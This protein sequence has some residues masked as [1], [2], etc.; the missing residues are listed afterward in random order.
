[1]FCT[2]TKAHIVVID[3]PLLDT[4]KYQDNL[5]NLITDLVLQILSW[6]AEEERTKIKVRQQEGIHLAKK[7]GKH[8]G[9]PRVEITEDFIMA[10]NSWQTGKVTAVEAMKQANL[11]KT[12]F[13]RLVKRF[14]N[15]T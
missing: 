12:T 10:Y 3:M 2:R 7:Q 13:Y 5:G 6:L 1:I 11:S 14:E 15:K 9:R 4:T 8:L